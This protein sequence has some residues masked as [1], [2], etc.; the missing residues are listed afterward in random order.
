MC[1]TYRP[2]S[3]AQSS[4]ADRARMIPGIA[5]SCIPRLAAFSHA[6]H[7]A[8]FSTLRGYA[9]YHFECQ[10]IDDRF[11]RCV[12]SVNG[13]SLRP[14]HPRGGYRGFFILFSVLFCSGRFVVFR[15]R[16]TGVT[17]CF[18]RYAIV[19][20]VLFS[21]RCLRTRS[22]ELSFRSLFT[23]LFPMKQ[24]ETL[25]RLHLVFQWRYMAFQSN[26]AFSWPRKRTRLCHRR[27][28]KARPL[29]QSQTRQQIRAAKPGTHIRAA[30]PR[31]KRRSDVL[32]GAV[33]SMEVVL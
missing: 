16:Y 33:Q 18:V 10:R 15:W 24:G 20:V 29:I 32:P 26:L 23:C 12:A 7:A 8:P 3:L 31:L 25:H 1:G 4:A 6:A 11:S 2:P 5:D 30:R 13:E 14:H 19:F 17:L 22:E 28:Q 9:L 21:A 27:T